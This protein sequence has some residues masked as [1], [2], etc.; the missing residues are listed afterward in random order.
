MKP[1][2]RPVISIIGMGIGFLLYALAGRLGD[3][4]DTLIISLIFVA[5]GVAAWFYATGERWIQVLGALLAAW[6]VIRALLIFL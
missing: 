6:G 2:P 5:L 4:W 1:W 3:P